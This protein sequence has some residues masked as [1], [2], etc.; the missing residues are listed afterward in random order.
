MNGFN[1]NFRELTTKRV[2]RYDYWDLKVGWGLKKWKLVARRT[3]QNVPNRLDFPLHWVSHWLFS[4]RSIK[5]Q[6]WAIGDIQD[7]KEMQTCGKKCLKNVSCW[8]RAIEVSAFKIHNCKSTQNRNDE[9]K[10]ATHSSLS[11][12]Q[13]NRLKSYLY[14]RQIEDFPWL[15]H[16]T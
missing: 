11:I 7:D 16:R 4:T 15:N 13:D 3:T 5:W 9:S 1:R 10:W 14:S 12:A 8:H 2:V 6:S